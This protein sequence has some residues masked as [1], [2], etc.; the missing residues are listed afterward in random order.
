M[1][2]LVIIGLVM[3][4][5]AVLF[6]LQNSVV[7]TISFGIWQL[8]QSLAIVLIATLG[9][10]MIISLFL[11]LPTI[12]QRKWQNTQ[13]Q[14]K[15][16]Q[17]QQQLRAKNQATLEQQQSTA[18]QQQSVQELLQA[19]SLTD[20]V[21]GVLNKETTIRLTEHLLQQ[22]QQ[23]KNPRYSSLVVILFSLDPA[24]SSRSF[25]DIGSENALYKAIAKRFKDAV[26]ADSFLGITERKRFISLVL[27][28]RGQEIQEYIAYLQNGI[29]ESP[30]QKADGV[31]LPL[32]MSA[33]GVVVDPTDTVD[34]R[35][36]LKLAEQNL[37]KSLAQGKGLVEISEV[38]LKS[39]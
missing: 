19:F 12:W 33:G 24:K 22:M 32:K 7:V 4:I 27:G 21:T 36:I 34:S 16:D 29:T 5:A 2:F 38:N 17:L 20:E 8:E 23:L 25:A 15:L 39:M 3:A 1:V 13:Q 30:L 26:I 18:A 11:S 28:L 37:E 6:A 14:S 31:L 10:G 9:L 35:Y